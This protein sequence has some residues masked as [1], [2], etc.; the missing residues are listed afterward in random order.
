M[1]VLTDEQTKWISNATAKVNKLI[2]ET[3]PNGDDF[4]KAVE[5]ILTR[6]QQWNAWKNEGCPAFT[7]KEKE[8]NDEKPNIV[9]NPIRKQRKRKLGD[10][11]RDAQE[12]PKKVYF[13]GNINLTKL[14]NLNPDNFEACAAPERDFLPS[15][16]G[17]FEEAIEQLNPENMVEDA[18]KYGRKKLIL[19]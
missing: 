10:Q 14:W 18:Y 4:R 17:Y 13:M 6:E 8:E 1:E 9:A 5:H 3:P 12:R 11:I 7:S 15:L 2:S 19:V 16:D